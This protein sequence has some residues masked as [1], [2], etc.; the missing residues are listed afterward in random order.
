MFDKKT[1]KQRNAPPISGKLSG[2]ATECLERREHER[3]S[4]IGDPFRVSGP[5][6]PHSP[7][8]VKEQSGQSPEGDGGRRDWGRG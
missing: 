2:E 3:E 7:L 6:Q 5:D 4:N 8:P 1:N